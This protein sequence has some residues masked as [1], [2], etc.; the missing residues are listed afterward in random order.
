M[1]IQ[2][3][4]QIIRDFNE[5]LSLENRHLLAKLEYC[6]EIDDPRY[7]DDYIYQTVLQYFR[8]KLIPHKIN[9]FNSGVELMKME[10]FKEFEIDE[11]EYL[12][13]LYIH[14]L[15]KFSAT[16]AIP[17]TFHDFSKKEFSLNFQIAW[18]HHKSKNEHHPEFWLNPSR[19][20]E[21][22][23]L[24]MPNIYILEMFADWIGAGLTY[25]DTIETWLPKNFHTFK[26]HIETE[27]KVRKIAKYLNIN[28]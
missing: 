26:F 15:S 22:S 21:I 16:E 14:D 8:E 20:G 2:N 10:W 6:Y 17:Y 27:S 1:K 9:V 11:D 5:K 12:Y 23:P 28:L 4:E 7:N 13:N 24:P 3:L 25:G 18:C 19:N